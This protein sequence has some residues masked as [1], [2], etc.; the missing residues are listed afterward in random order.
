MPEL[1]GGAT[2]ALAARS[3]RTTGYHSDRPCHSTASAVLESPIGATPISEQ[4]DHDARRAQAFRNSAAVLAR[5]Q[6]REAQPIG[7]L[8]WPQFAEVCA[9]LGVTLRGEA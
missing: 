8:V 3:G 1:D 7:E 6:D 5:W 4:F 2:L 9:Q